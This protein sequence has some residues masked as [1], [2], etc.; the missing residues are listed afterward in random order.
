MSD[1]EF[2]E[3]GIFIINYFISLIYRFLPPGSYIDVRNHTM[4]ELATIIFG[5]INSPKVYSN[6]FRWKSLYTYSDPTSKENV[7]AVCAAI[8]NKQMMETKSTYYEFRK[9]WNPS[10]KRRCKSPT[11]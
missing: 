6:F 4:F 7:C 11:I 1:F 8:N 5:L 2:I 3:L 10:F 9:W